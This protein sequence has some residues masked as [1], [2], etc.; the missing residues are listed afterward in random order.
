MVWEPKASGNEDEK[1][2]LSEF[3]VGYIFLCSTAFDAS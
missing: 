2:M 1:R 3:P